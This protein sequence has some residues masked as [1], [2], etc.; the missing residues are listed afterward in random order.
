MSITFLIPI[1]NEVKTVR[2]AIE[3][4]IKLDVPS[5]EII[6][7]DNKSTDGSRDIIDEYRNR[8]NIHIIY[9]KKNLGFGLSLIHI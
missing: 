7:I 2:K 5:K 1:Y 3:E 6:I 8:K 4:T 9:Q